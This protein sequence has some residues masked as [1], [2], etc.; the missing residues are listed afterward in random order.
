[1]YDLYPEERRSCPEV[2]ADILIIHI[3]INFFSN[4][5]EFFASITGCNSEVNHMLF[6]T[7]CEEILYKRLKWKAGHRGKKQ[8]D[9]TEDSQE[10]KNYPKIISKELFRLTNDHMSLRMRSTNAITLSMDKLS[11]EK[12]Q[13]VDVWDVLWIQ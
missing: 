4:Y 2:T 3:S 5:T 8:C 7:K 11:S 13:T 10:A 6:R 12:H 1:M 9:K